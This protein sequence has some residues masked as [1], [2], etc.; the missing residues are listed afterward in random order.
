MEK[1][2]PVKFL[3]AILVSCSFVCAATT[4]TV[5]G[6]VA[7]P[8]GAMIP[9]AHVTIVNEGTNETRRIE[10]DGS[11]AFEFLLL[12]VGT[13]T[14]RVEETKFNTYLLR[15]IILSVNQ[16]ATFNLSLQIGAIGSVV[17]VEANPLEVDTVSTQLG[18]VIDSRPIRDLPLNGR[19]VY[20]LM[21]LQPGVSVP[22]GGGGNPSM[23]GVGPAV[24][25]SGGG[26][27]TMNNFMVDGGDTNGTYA[28]EA[29]VELIPDAVEEF[30]VITSSANAEF[31]RNAGSV[32]NVISK[33]GSNSWH[34]NAFE[35]LRNELLN[36]RNFFEID[37]A[38]F[39]LNQFGG[40]LGG[41]IQ[42]DK[43]FFFGSFQ[44]SL[45][46]QGISGSL[47]RVFSDSERSGDFSAR[48]P[49]GFSGALTDPLCF[50]SDGT[51]AQNCYPAG[52]SYNDIF[53][54]AII[55]S[56]FF[57]PVSQRIV[58]D[59]LPRAN[60]GGQYL[61]VTPVQPQN[62][63]RWTMKI[64]HNLGKKH[65]LSGFYF[66]DDLTSHNVGVLSSS[67]PGFPV[68]TEVRYQQFSLADTWVINPRT[69]N[70]FHLGYLRKGAGKENNPER[71]I[72]MASL[73]F[74]GITPGE[75]LA[76][77]TLP[78][79]NIQGGPVFQ[80][81]LTGS[82]GGR[83]FQNTFQFTDNFSKVLGRHSLKFGAD[84]RRL[85]Y[86]QTL[87]YSYDGNFSFTDGGPNTT[88]DSFANFVLGLPTTYLQ[89]VQSNQR[90]SSSH[91]NLYAQDSWKLRSN[92]TLNYGL[93][94]EL[95]TPFVE[96]DN[97]FQVF[98]FPSDSG[99]PA[100]QSTIYPTAPPGYLFPGDSGVPR[101]LTNTYYRAFG[102]RVGLAYSP[103]WLG[104]NS[105]VI[106][107]AFGIFYNPV[108]QF[109]L[110][111]FNGNPP[112]GASTF[113]SSPGFANPF[114]DQSGNQLPSP[115]PY[116]LPKAGQ[117]V[118][119]NQFYPIL[120]YGQFLPDQRPQYMEQYNLMMEYQVS[121]STLL[122]L[123][124]VGSQ[125]HRLLANYDMN[126]GNPDLCLQ[127]ASQGCG[128]FGRTT[129]TLEP[130]EKPS[131][132]HARRALFPTTAISK[133]SATSLRNTPF[134]I[135]IIIPCRPAWNG[136]PHRPSFWRRTLIPNPSTMLPVR[137][138]SSILT[139]SG[140]TGLYPALMCGTGSCSVILTG[141]QSLS[142][143]IRRPS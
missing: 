60:S 61:V 93:R 9:K 105:L 7:D 98:R 106:R 64:D 113:I 120:M 139:V 104:A 55:P 57:N 92:L 42:K 102:P 19:N 108:E 53:P 87:V 141:C 39:K 23:G 109:V 81:P 116:Q 28:N 6:T 122:A 24:F 123:G 76:L 27:L 73:G 77:Q 20:Q 131:S 129:I 103:G 44:T 26:R 52:T 100:P 62:D 38:P 49:N 58:S 54:G 72:P 4:G 121:P 13:Y 48:N 65:K 137:K 96:R 135:P 45:R 68:M 75:P 133:P 29:T 117:T 8:S 118:D 46:R 89:G 112:F 31:G 90:L 134:Q 41:P 138:I 94:W 125:G 32:V 18:T 40:T 16:V 107:A 66:F 111:Q 115:Y 12:P 143:S 50:P 30:R 95:S 67:L 130:R 78:A 88:G 126:P 119:F 37:R 14:L 33:S 25:S 127:L 110:L 56:S 1:M 114:V 91:V 80:D 71:A 85:R 3:I 136:A 82:G 51:G 99:Q 17:Q 84:L 36:A 15:G 35:F 59:F 79:I 34:G 132:G 43:T 83:D 142:V 70:E 22:H 124:Y 63:Y 69:L 5:R 74:T 21:V 86:N 101:G 10:S 140:A 11:G 97:L 47:R 2:F 128:P